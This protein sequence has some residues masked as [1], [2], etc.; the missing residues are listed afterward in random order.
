[1]AITI[2]SI[3][4]KGGLNWRGHFTTTISASDVVNHLQN[5]VLHLPINPSLRT[6]HGPST[7]AYV[8]TV[9]TIRAEDL[10][11]SATPTNFTEKILDAYG[12]NIKYKKDIIDKIKPF[13]FP[14][15]DQIA[16]AMRNPSIEQALTNL[17]FWGANL[18]DINRFSRFRYSPQTGYYVIYLDTEKIL[19]D[20]CEDPL[21]QKIPGVFT[22]QRIYG[23]KDAEIRWDVQLDITDGKISSYATNPFEVSIDKIIATAR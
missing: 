19:K 13:M 1:M 7:G 22:V 16:N 3:S 5:E 9:L 18:V 14:E 11:V 4:T 6:I 10:A 8:V 15:P 23:N 12:S 2:P 17:G 20:M 21:E